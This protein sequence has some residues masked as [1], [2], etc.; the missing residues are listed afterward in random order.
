MTTETVADPVGHISISGVHGRDELNERLAHA[1]RYVPPNG[2]RGGSTASLVASAVVGAAL[3][4]LF[5][6]VQGQRR[7][8]MLRDAFVRGLKASSDRLGG[9]KRDVDATA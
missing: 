4:Y 2:R 7:R 1:P 9:V 6:P 8:S 5:D 3:M